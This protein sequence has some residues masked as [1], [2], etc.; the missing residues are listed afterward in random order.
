M[1][2]IRKGDQVKVIAGN[3]R[4]KE[5]EVLQVSP[6]ERRILVRGVNV[7]KRHQRPTSR[8]HEGGIVEREAPI[9]VSNAMVVCPECDHPARVG[10]Q[11]DE[12]GAKMRVCRQCGE[13]FD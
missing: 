10:F 7:I 2:A 1:Q 8:Q 5:G 12:D 9:H 4:G 6:K 13:M 3:D 11:R